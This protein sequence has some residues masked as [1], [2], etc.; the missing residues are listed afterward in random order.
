VSVVLPID[1]IAG[2]RTVS[3]VLLIEGTASR[4]A[5]SLEWRAFLVFC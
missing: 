2:R 5:L 1:R 4:R 3:V